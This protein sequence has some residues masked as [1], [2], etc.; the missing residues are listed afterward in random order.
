MR[1][2][3]IGAFFAVSMLVLF[4]AP[5]SF[6]RAADNCPANK[7]GM[8][9]IYSRK[10][11]DK[12]CVA[13]NG[14]DSD[15][16]CT[17][18]GKDCPCT[19]TVSGKTYKGLCAGVNNCVTPPVPDGKEATAPA[20]KCGGSGQPACPKTTDGTK[21][22]N[23]PPPATPGP[24][25]PAENA[26][27]SCGDSASCEEY[28]KQLEAVESG[29]QDTI[30]TPADNAGSSRSPSDPRYYSS[31]NDPA[32]PSGGPEPAD[33]AGSSRGTFTGG[34]LPEA[35]SNW[36][37]GSS[38]GSLSPGGGFNPS[39]SLGPAGGIGPGGVVPATPLQ[40]SVSGSSL[41]G[42]GAPT[43]GSTF[44][45]NDITGSLPP[46]PGGARSPIQTAASK[47]GSPTY[48]NDIATGANTALGDL[49]GFDAPI[50]GTDPQ[51]NQF[52]GNAPGVPPAPSAAQSTSPWQTTSTQPPSASQGPSLGDPLSGDQV[53]Q[54]EP[55]GGPGDTLPPSSGQTGFQNVPTAQTPQVAGFGPPD[56]STAPWPGEGGAPP[57]TQPPFTVTPS[58]AATPQGTQP[59]DFKGTPVEQLT[60]P[61]DVVNGPPEQRSSTPFA[62]Y[63][64]QP[65][66]AA[67]AS[68]ARTSSL[69]ELVRA[70]ARPDWV[71]AIVA[72]PENPVLL[73]GTGAGLPGW[74]PASIGSIY[75]AAASK[76]VG[77]GIPATNTGN[78]NPLQF[79]NLADAD[80][81]GAGWAGA[82]AD[83]A[84]PLASAGPP[85]P[86]SPRTE[87]SYAPGSVLS[88]PPAGSDL[89][90]DYG[91]SF[92]DV[93]ADTASTPPLTQGESDLAA[94]VES[95]NPV[96]PVSE[97]TRS[98]GSL[99]GDAARGAANI[100]SNAW[101]VLTGAPV[102][103]GPA[104]IEGGETTGDPNALTPGEA[105]TEFLAQ[106]PQMQP[107]LEGP[108][109][110]GAATRDERLQQAA[111]ETG[112]VP[113][114][115]TGPLRDP[116]TD[117]PLAL[118]PK[119]PS[120]NEPGT[121]DDLTDKVM[122]RDRGL[123]NANQAAREAA[124]RESEWRLKEE[125]AQRATEQAQAAADDQCRAT[126]GC[127]ITT[128]TATGK[129]GK[130]L[131]D[132]YGQPLTYN[133]Y[134]CPKGGCAA[135]KTQI[136]ALK[137]K[138]N[139]LNDSR[140]NSPERLAAS[141]A[142]KNYTDAF[143]TAKAA[144]DE[145]QKAADTLADAAVPS[146]VVANSLYNKELQA[147]RDLGLA[148]VAAS[149][150]YATPAQLA[151]AK[152]AQAAAQQA[153]DQIDAQKNFM[154]TSPYRD[155]VSESLLKPSE[156]LSPTDAANI[157]HFGD[158][159]A[160][161][162]YANQAAIAPNSLDRNAALLESYKANAS[163]QLFDPGNSDD[164]FKALTVAEAL[165]TSPEA[166]TPV[167]SLTVKA[168][169][170]S[171]LKQATAQ[172]NNELALA[173]TNPDWQ[174]F[175][176]R[177]ASLAERSATFADNILNDLSS[178]FP[179]SAETQRLIS[180]ED[181]LSW[182]SLKQS[183]TSGSQFFK[184]QYESTSWW[185]IDRKLGSALFGGIYDSAVNVV[186]TIGDA[187]GIEPLQDFTLPD[188]VYANATEPWES[189]AGRLG[190][191]A[192][193]VWAGA[194]LMRL[195]A[196]GM[197]A[198]GG[199]IYRAT[200]GRGLTTWDVSAA[201]ALGRV[202]TDLGSQYPT[203]TGT[204]GGRF[205][206]YWGS[207]SLRPTSV[208]GGAA[209][210]SLPAE[211][212]TAGVGEPISTGVP[213]TLEPVVEGLTTRYALGGLN[214]YSFY[215]PPAFAQLPG[216]VTYN[217]ATKIERSGD[218]QFVATASDEVGGSTFEWRASQP[219]RGPLQAYNELRARYG[220]E[221]VEAAPLEANATTRVASP[222]TLQD[223]SGYPAT[224]REVAGEL[225]PTL[226]GPRP[227]ALTN[228]ER[229]AIDAAN[230][231]GTGGP[232]R[233]DVLD[234]KIQD[235]RAAD[236]R[237][238]EPS[239]AQMKNSLPS[240]T[241]Q[242]TDGTVVGIY[243]PP[244]AS[245]VPVNPVLRGT[246]ATPQE[247]AAIRGYY[248]SLGTDAEQSALAGLREQGLG[249]RF[250]GSQLRPVG[251][252]DVG[253][254]AGARPGEVYRLGTRERLAGLRSDGS[255]GIYDPSLSRVT[256]ETIARA[257]EAIAAVQRQVLET[258][259]I[260]PTSIP[261]VEAGPLVPEVL[262][263]G[264]G[265]IF[266]S[267]PQSLKNAFAAGNAL[268]A[269][270]A[271]G[272][273]DVGAA[274]ARP[275]II[276]QVTQA[277]ASASW[278]AI[279]ASIERTV[280]SSTLQ[281]SIATAGSSIA[282]GVTTGLTNSIARLALS[283]V[284]GA[285]LLTSL[286]SAIASPAAPTVST[287]AS[288]PSAGAPAIDA[289][290]SLQAAPSAPSVAAP[291]TASVSAPGAPS[292][293]APSSPSAP[294][295]TAPSTP[296]APAPS[297]GGPA[298]PAPS[299]GGPTTPGQAP[300]SAP[301]QAAPTQSAV[302]A[303]VR[304]IS[305]AVSSIPLPPTF[306]MAV[307][308]LGA[309]L[310]S[311]PSAAGPA[312]S[313]TELF[314]QVA[315]SDV[316]LPRPNPL[317]EYW[318]LQQQVID[319]LAQS[320]AR[321][322]SPDLLWRLYG[323]D[324]T[325]I[326][327]SRES[328]Q[329]LQE[330]I[331]PNPPEF[332]RSVPE[333]RTQ[334]DQLLIT[335]SKEE[336]VLATLE[337]ADLTNAFWA[338]A[339]RGASVSAY[340]PNVIVFDADT[341]GRLG[342][343]VFWQ[344]QTFYDPMNNTVY[345]NVDQLKNYLI[346]T[347][348][349][350]T[351]NFI[352]VVMAHEVGHHYTLVLNKG[353]IMS[354][355]DPRLQREFETAADFLAGLSM[356]DVNDPVY[357][358]YSA[359]ALGSNIRML[360]ADQPLAAVSESEGKSTH[361]SS[362]ER[363]QAWLAGYNAPDTRA[364]IARLFAEN[365]K[366][367]FST[368]NTAPDVS[369]PA[370][371][372]RVPAD[373]NTEFNVNDFVAQ[374]VDAAVIAGVDTT[375]RLYS[376]NPDA[377]KNM[378]T[379]EALNNSRIAAEQWAAQQPNNGEVTG[380][381]PQAAS[382][383]NLPSWLRALEEWF[384]NSTIGSILNAIMGAPVSPGATAPSSQSVTSQQSYVS[385][386]AEVFTDD[387]AAPALQ[388][389]SAWRE[390]LGKLLRGEY[391][392][393]N[394]V[395]PSEARQ[396][397]LKEFADDG[398]AVQ[399]KLVERTR[400]NVEGLE[401]ILGKP[402]QVIEDYRDGLAYGKTAT[403]NKQP[404]RQVYMHNTSDEA[405]PGTKA[406]GTPGKS[407]GYY[408]FA[409]HEDNAARGGRVGAPV[410][411]GLD[412]DGIYKII[413]TSKTGV[414][415][416]QAKGHNEYSYGIEWMAKEGAPM[417][418]QDKLVFFALIKSI[419]E[420][421]PGIAFVA[422]PDTSP[423]KDPLEARAQKQ[424]VASLPGTTVVKGSGKAQYFVLASSP[425][426]PSQTLASAPSPQTTGSLPAASNTGV[427]TQA[428][429]NS[430]QLPGTP[431]PLSPPSSGELPPA[432]VVPIPVPPPAVPGPQPRTVL[433][434]S[435]TNVQAPAGFT[436]TLR[437][438][439]NAPSGEP[440]E[441][442]A[443]SLI[444]HDAPSWLYILA[445]ITDQRLTG[446][447]NTTTYV[448][449]N[450]VQ[451][452]YGA[453]VQNT[454]ERLKQIEA[455]VTATLYTMKH[456]GAPAKL[457]MVEVKNNL[458]SWLSQAGI[459]ENALI[460]TGQNSAGQP[461]FKGTSGK[462][463]TVG[464]LETGQRYRVALDTNKMYS[465]QELRTQFPELAAFFRSSLN[466]EMLARAEGR[467]GTTADWG[468]KDTI[469]PTN[470]DTRKAALSLPGSLAA[471]KNQITVPQ[472]IISAVLAGY[473][474]ASEK[475][476][477]ET[478]EL[479]T[480]TS[481]NRSPDVNRESNGAA[482]SDHLVGMAID[483]RDYTKGGFNGSKA[484]QDRFTALMR[485]E[486]F[487]ADRHTVR[488]GVVHVH[489][490]MGP[491]AEGTK[492]T[493]PTGPASSIVETTLPSNQYGVFVDG[494]PL[495]DARGTPFALAPDVTIAG[496]APT[497]LVPR[498]AVVAGPALDRSKL[499][500]PKEGTDAEGDEERTISDTDILVMR[501]LED[502]MRALSPLS[503]HV[504]QYRGVLVSG[505]AGN[506]MQESN[507]DPETNLNTS[508]N[509]Y[510][511]PQQL[512]LWQVRRAIEAGNLLL[513]T[514]RLT[515][516]GAQIVKDVI[517][518]SASALELIKG[519]DR[520]PRNPAYDPYLGAALGVL[521]HFSLL[522]DT[523][524]VTADSILN[525][526]NALDNAVKYAGNDPQ[527]VAAVLHL[528]QLAPSTMSNF[529]LD[530]R[531]TGA[532]RRALRPNSVPV[533]SK[534]TIQ[535]VLDYLTKTRSL[536]GK[537]FAR[538]ITVASQYA[539][540]ET[541]GVG[542]TT[543]TIPAP[544]ELDLPSVRQVPDAI[545][546]PKPLE[547]TG[548][549]I[550]TLPGVGEK[551]LSEQLLRQA[552]EQQA[553]ALKER[554]AA[555]KARAERAVADAKLMAELE[556]MRPVIEDFA[557]AKPEAV[558]ALNRWIQEREARLAAELAA[559]ER[560]QQ[561]RQRLNEL[562]PLVR[563][564]EFAQQ[565]DEIRTIMDTINAWYDEYQQRLGAERLAA[566]R[567]LADAAFR[568][569]EEAR[570][571]KQ[572][573]VDTAIAD[574]LRLQA[575]ADQA[576]WNTTA[577]KVTVAVSEWTAL[578]RDAAAALDALDAATAQSRSTIEAA[579]AP[580]ADEEGFVDLVNVSRLYQNVA[581][582]KA[583]QELWDMRVQLA[584]A[585][586][587]R[588]AFVDNIL[589]AFQSHLRVVQ[590]A[591]DGWQAAMDAEAL[592]AAE[593]EQAEAQARLAAE[594]QKREELQTLYGESY[595]AL[596]EDTLLE[597]L[598][599]A[600]VR[601]P[602]D[603]Y[604]LQAQ[605]DAEAA[606][607]IADENARLDHELRARDVA[608][609][610]Q[611]QIQT[612]LA[613]IRALGAQADAVAWSVKA[614]EVNADVQAWNALIRDVTAALQGQVAIDA[615]QA[616]ARA[617]LS[618]VQMQTA[619]DAANAAQAADA[620]EA[621]A[622]RQYYLD[623]ASQLETAIAEVNG[624]LALQITPA[625]PVSA[626]NT[627]PAEA[628]NRSISTINAALTPA[629]KADILS[630]LITQRQN[631][632]KIASDI[633]AARAAQLEI[634]ALQQDFIAKVSALARATDQSI[635]NVNA[636]LAPS[637]RPDALVS[638]DAQ[639]K[640]A[641][642]LESDMQAARAA[643]QEVGAQ[644]QR[645]IDETN[646][647]IAATD[648]SVATIEAAQARPTNILASLVSQQQ[649]AD[650]LAGNVTDTRAALQEISVL[651]QEVA[652]TMGA[653]I[654]AT[655]RSESTI[656][657][658]LAPS[659]RS[660]VLA[661]LLSQ[662][663]NAISLA[664]NIQKAQTL[665]QQLDAEMQIVIDAVDAF[666]GL[667]VRSY[668]N[669]N[670]ALAPSAGNTLVS[671][672]SGTLGR[673]SLSLALPKLQNIPVAT[674]AETY[675]HAANNAERIALLKVKSDEIDAAIPLVQEANAKQA[676]LDA[677][678]AA[679]GDALKQLSDLKVKYNKE[680][681]QPSNP[682]A[683]KRLDQTA[684]DLEVVRKDVTRQ[685]AAAA[686][687]GKRSGATANIGIL[688]FLF[689]PAKITNA[690]D[691]GQKTI[692]AG[693]RVAATA[694]K[695]SSIISKDLINNPDIVKNENR[696]ALIKAKKSYDA[697]Q[698][699]LLRSLNQANALL[700]F[701]HTALWSNLS[702]LMSLGSSQAALTAQAKSA[703]ALLKQRG[704]ALAGPIQKVLDDALKQASEPKGAP[705]D[706]QKEMASLEA[707]AKALGEQIALRQADP[708]LAN[709]PVVDTTGIVNI[710]K[711]G[712]TGAVSA[713]SPRLRN[714]RALNSQLTELKAAAT[715]AQVA[716]NAIPESEGMSRLATARILTGQ[717]VPLSEGIRDL[718]INKSGLLDMNTING[719]MIDI[720]KVSYR[721]EVLKDAEITKKLADLGV[722]IT[723]TQLSLP[724]A[725][726][727][728]V[729]SAA[730][731]NTRINYS[732]PWLALHSDGAT[733]LGFFVGDLA[734]LFDEPA[735]RLLNTAIAQAGATDGSADLTNI[736]STV[737]E[738]RAARSAVQTQLAGLQQPDVQVAEVQGQKGETTGS[739][740]QQTGSTIGRW[741]NTLVSSLTSG[742]ATW[743]LLRPSTPRVPAAPA[744]TPSTGKPA[745]PTS[746]SGQKDGGSSESSSPWARV[747][748]EVPGAGAG[749]GTGGTGATPPKEATPAIQKPASLV[750]FRIP[751]FGTI[752]AI[753]L[754][755]T[756][757][758][759]G[760]ETQE[761]SKGGATPGGVPK[762]PGSAGTTATTPGT[763][764]TV[765]PA[766]AS[767]ASQGGPTPSDS[768]K[769]TTTKVEATGGPI[770]TTLAPL[771][772]NTPKCT[773]GRGTFQPGVT[774]FG[775]CAATGQITPA[776]TRVT[777]PSVQPGSDLTQKTPIPQQKGPITGGDKG[778][779]TTPGPTTTKV[780]TGPGTIPPSQPRQPTAP[781]AG[782]FVTPPS[783]AGGGAGQGGMFG[784]GQMVGNF[785]KN[786]FG[787][788][789]AQS[790]SEQAAGE[791]QQTTATTNPQTPPYVYLTASQTS[792]QKGSTVTLT[793]SSGDATACGITSSDGTKISSDF[794]GSIQ[795]P[796]LQSTTSFTLECGNVMG[797][798]RSAVIVQVEGGGPTPSTN[799]GQV[800][801]M[802]QEARPPY[803]LLGATPSTID[804]GARSVLSWTTSNATFC[805]VIGDDG[806]KLSNEQSGSVQTPALQKT[807]S[808]VLQ[809][810]NTA[811][812]SK[813]VALV[814]VRAAP[815]NTAS[816]T[817]SSATS[818]LPQVLISVSQ[819]LVVTGQ[820]VTLTW[821]T[822]NADSC[823]IFGS[824]GTHVVGAGGG[825]LETA[826]I[827]AQTT[828]T[829]QCQN[830]HG[831]ARASAVVS[832]S[833][834]LP[835]SFASDSP[836][837]AATP[838]PPYILIG[839][840][841]TQQ[842]ST[843]TTAKPST[844]VPA[845]AAQA[846]SVGSASPSTGSSASPSTSSGSSA[847]V[848][849][850]PSLPMLM[851]GAV[852]TSVAPGGTS[853]IS[854]TSAN[855]TACGVGKPDGTILA[856]GLGGIYTTP[857]LTQT[858]TYEIAC[859]N[860]AGDTTK[861]LTIAVQ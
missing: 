468:K 548:G 685:G 156:S 103:G 18:G 47:I 810:S 258:P 803:V 592:A 815:S 742:F 603:S 329:N 75:S 269:I 543:A 428:V 452:L 10:C 644:M 517:D 725:A 661:S 630:S 388:P 805:E 54:Y 19:R 242:R 28:E 451:E 627:A 11:G 251:G 760:T 461:Q 619:L 711:S 359:G 436:Q 573:R 385:D 211:L 319:T 159:V 730:E 158:S 77:D 413:F 415:T 143:N 508:D 131:K 126:P 852:P 522:S 498:G 273:A 620:A 843:Q 139:E 193:N 441:I 398:D 814:S 295:V 463:Y 302:P 585:E 403:A 314:Q 702:R 1:V 499:P 845:P 184:D 16:K 361:P 611:V 324:K 400:A 348:P 469:T 360:R 171:I 147:N 446:A 560:A 195:T 696:E 372:E 222:R 213:S 40:S 73:T 142:Y 588:A 782:P 276:A 177:N 308:S 298:S 792:V 22:S 796:A 541:A 698:R 354:S 697:A 297:V 743:V 563:Q 160:R 99:L 426:Y 13:Q 634:D 479:P 250:G 639:R 621:A 748:G 681:T 545:F 186:G 26:G 190:L 365:E 218:T 676:E 366:L 842:G 136:D 664:G 427:P 304:S 531:L 825:S 600:T 266:S 182:S 687:A 515:P 490:A 677:L 523:Q 23:A 582:A 274:I 172:I 316:P 91:K 755:L 823:H 414:R 819:E 341:A 196:R 154:A 45:P 32:F 568:L 704:L 294:G 652:D 457:A 70:A 609:M 735:T 49:S 624:V 83:T 800:G 178:G 530:R 606:R 301:T 106:A 770:P 475:F 122:E 849:P 430:G 72:N 833:D 571:F 762:K 693:I 97:P 757:F 745:T 512:R 201:G 495:K 369:S 292:V 9:V 608:L 731:S 577:S 513:A 226:G 85:A 335:M 64:L 277:G 229:N 567:Q 646:A 554:Q 419:N 484:L 89:E 256:P 328:L 487:Y 780:P 247:L 610:R 86:N 161:D 206:N 832:V 109:D 649:K 492:W 116:N 686:A 322:F 565:A 216:N 788:G 632:G 797:N 402:V 35:I 785:F 459:K 262:P 768:N 480:G 723:G 60:V 561:Q 241:I 63:P 114:P 633:A 405:I 617:E 653:H 647:L 435:D 192:V 224:T 737:D 856:T 368:S 836:A 300:S 214:Q 98:T 764:G 260:S 597:I 713:E 325:N 527:K 615:A 189:Q 666:L 263:E 727:L 710:A 486:G 440:A 572:L 813:S 37:G 52:L 581:D 432:Q 227:G 514:G 204:V 393:L 310:G 673:T 240:N 835:P 851:I 547:Q 373:F 827:L 520:D 559:V 473:V 404:L 207:M 829:L 562:R 340:P 828:F 791:Q 550:A 225:S 67:Q 519:N 607:R 846:T 173:A 431:G 134:S 237:F 318:Q 123:A 525:A 576:A 766:P 84:P 271:G 27:S 447:E 668:D 145:Y 641:V 353:G 386:A 56:N 691:Q 12:K 552:N 401:K 516:E 92:G 557:V 758:L 821:T 736:A 416:A 96:P 776:Q 546:S 29:K 695:V 759:S 146:S 390:W 718:A 342:I 719:T 507:F 280:V 700:N 675:A 352:R 728:F 120:P 847:A 36:F 185:Q 839:T 672:T 39:G 287:P 100:V 594:L 442:A 187:T 747:P 705:A 31:L 166:R 659:G 472:G 338:D 458:A 409:A 688:D 303:V 44:G 155:A 771:P 638:L 663:Q 555:Q 726:K 544:S 443:Q 505:E 586:A 46:N 816:T 378:P 437:N 307:R 679:R 533:T 424:F 249:T 580:S 375:V 751:F 587:E 17:I 379:A 163:A 223:I 174:I 82:M 356:Q 497:P 259:S 807:T 333:P 761:E 532:E 781:P 66:P 188:R 121:P 194:D 734:K 362:R 717:V 48:G 246:A 254:P 722:K 521:R 564:L 183:V 732:V 690:L 327:N 58:Q 291:A 537:N 746:P 720:S 494:T 806:S 128:K 553:Q 712:G 625:T 433:P 88:E 50:P 326:S 150:P 104:S 380:S 637:Q 21:G 456:P 750:R 502:M 74:T 165:N 382:R 383:Q 583:A 4:F 268:V 779:P 596:A 714:L 542:E 535:S 305:N 7:D 733:Q 859:I 24:Y 651:L 643:Q 574:G 509:S 853:D 684:K 215:A 628:T 140:T 674:W 220:L 613:E 804:A 425:S 230:A 434:A 500:A 141:D 117:L 795:T 198:I 826:P 337:A 2:F 320:G 119:Q 753:G 270:G 321:A 293:A 591:V 834:W 496:V 132:E 358:Y 445:R 148:T 299:Q 344:N 450:A 151:E 485:A 420:V 33:Y 860:A 3:R 167:Q 129:D 707:K 197:G 95:K 605:A 71:S 408:T 464:A 584:I 474:R 744:T 236:L 683:I 631:A 670:I 399:A 20:T 470:P 503:P 692:R 392:T 658:A 312:Q 205:Q 228:A 286:A 105:E 539:A 786:L 202:G 42:N 93:M 831:Y 820:S 612:A 822:H 794:G 381:I 798:A 53:P 315:Q 257:N 125:Y 749:G 252:G 180:N 265:G 789:G 667:T 203:L 569:Q 534:S 243:D 357:S 858:T 57:A 793:W 654:A 844:G 34:I 784:L 579:F 465:V 739:V 282:A 604:I 616:L 133:T 767:P 491:F 640:S 130:P 62:N 808:Y 422:H 769:I 454:P 25:E 309:L 343:P 466:S 281:P 444:T 124:I 773:D 157:K 389:A 540:L 566:E 87:P 209:T 595:T 239:N 199:D 471:Y 406:P 756:P 248:A 346:R 715:R 112:D 313:L 176:Q 799:P 636:A 481:L 210:E 529:D 724:D 164:R 777:T 841:T 418:E 289:A 394:P 738:L 244:S 467:G 102:T 14:D 840:T 642:K 830:A 288:V 110:P 351:K 101:G 51:G 311:S 323:L 234:A 317:R 38:Q 602:L 370:L 78:A 5:L 6:A 703:G 716:L 551:F 179:P 395:S 429:A 330:F 439:F 296:S 367:Y 635:S 61:P 622:Q 137:A 855:A 614:G 283:S 817:Q 363:A 526:P 740:P 108:T 655:A 272:L 538:G 648:R 775:L 660:D 850:A 721:D 332:T 578:S 729:V 482:N 678:I 331:F 275:A 376:E 407:L 90:S 493:Q 245:Y 790:G 111:A 162:L 501:G 438:L 453:G 598:G 754:G 765:A 233:A 838:T 524:R 618:R 235:L 208:T 662:K 837:A 599:E 824:D 217:G 65:S 601:S 558:E 175:Y 629:A 657:A 778:I 349:T 350:A 387:I 94:L 801:Q 238:S 741:V 671:L 590:N 772:A 665:Q 153:L 255:Y 212:R 169:E 113:L 689:N 488:G 397:K 80:P 656:R 168:Y 489:F 478:G 589:A 69:E 818:S 334:G 809:C 575:E 347:W 15:T 861:Q 476:Y 417:N 339:L 279:P 645:V 410:Y 812:Y 290:P 623:A 570:L 107:T 680:L 460:Y 170:T 752:A 449:N 68:G 412:E 364:E 511:G 118:M 384:N 30:Y 149:D 261:Y 536:H 264:S 200:L 144:S 345:F 396:L 701:D 774:H 135:T 682:E 423:E 421:F 355:E 306:Q 504:A 448:R 506:V 115:T 518:R 41:S 556:G 391:F 783:S 848:A 253:I 708:A 411:A 181:P 231:R 857:P 699:S 371:G 802:Q 267:V 43:T 477:M 127:S 377:L 336:F 709:V 462:V 787:F 284:P 694:G 650:V 528:A 55:G 8:E 232:F 549:L 706:V 81:T 79:G 593:K 59:N 152:S 285:A 811:G 455:D 76:Y 278:A 626:E 763:G 221:P 510:K 374:S 854:W 219:E 483:V 138:V 191:D 669:I